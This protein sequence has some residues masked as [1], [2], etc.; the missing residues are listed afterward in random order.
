[1]SDDT[2][3]SKQPAEIRELVQDATIFY[4]D[5]DP[6]IAGIARV[7][8]LHTDAMVTVMVYDMAKVVDILV[9]QGMTEDEAEEF[10]E[11]NT[12]GGWLGPYTPMHMWRVC[13]E[14][15]DEVMEGKPMPDGYMGTGHR[16]GQ[17]D[18]ALFE[19]GKAGVPVTIEGETMSPVYVTL[20]EPI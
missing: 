9:A 16:C 12:I 2:W 4:P 20:V 7:P 5:Y 14:R 11:F 18:V 6:A 19:R 13:Q 8:L 1:M 3:L 10:L 17:D 15:W